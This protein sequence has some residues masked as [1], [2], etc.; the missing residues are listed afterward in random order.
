MQYGDLCFIAAGARRRPEIRQ[1]QNPGVGDGDG[2][3]GPAAANPLSRLSQVT[4]DGGG[5]ANPLTITS[6]VTG[7][8]GGPT[9]PLT[10]T[11]QV[12]GDGG[13]PIGP[14]SQALGI[15]IATLALRGAGAL[16]PAPVGAV[17]LL[18]FHLAFVAVAALVLVAMAGVF[19]L[20]PDAGD[21]VRVRA[22]KMPAATSKA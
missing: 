5:P 11:S 9:N 10:I 4:G 22:A 20:D 21:A 13:G 7:D 15:G 19:R 16:F 1:A 14:M 6:Q 2:P 18:H 17:P 3:G 8:G 12:T